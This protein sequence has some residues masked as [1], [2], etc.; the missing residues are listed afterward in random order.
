VSNIHTYTI[1][2][3]NIIADVAL[4]HDQALKFT[5]DVVQVSV[6]VITS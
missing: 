5:G 1:C 2:H 3:L 4:V 6:G